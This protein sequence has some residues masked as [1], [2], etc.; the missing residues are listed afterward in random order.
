MLSSVLE[1]WVF[2]FLRNLELLKPFARG[3][4]FVK[5]VCDGE[6]FFQCYCSWKNFIRKTEVSIIVPYIKEISEFTQSLHIGPV[7]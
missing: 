3:G 6:F 7:N 5:F 4:N 2:D 1:Y